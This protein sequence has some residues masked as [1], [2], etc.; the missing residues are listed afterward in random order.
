MGRQRLAQP[1]V[2]LNMRVDAEVLSALRSS[3]KG[4][5]SRVNALLRNAVA[6]G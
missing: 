3:G 5:Q 2:A 6:S 4:W 1:K